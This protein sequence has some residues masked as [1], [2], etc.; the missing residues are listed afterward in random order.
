LCEGE[1]A[2]AA[3]E[4]YVQSL[5]SG[6]LVCA[7]VGHDQIRDLV[8]IEVFGGDSSR[9]EPADLHIVAAEADVIRVGARPDAECDHQHD[10]RERRQEANVA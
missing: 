4:E 3:A 9:S 5:R 10:Q 8:S 1:C 2:V 6:D 7:K